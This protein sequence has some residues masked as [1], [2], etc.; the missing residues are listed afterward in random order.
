MSLRERS[1]SLLLV[2]SAKHANASLTEI[3]LECPCEKPV[4]VSSVSAAEQALADRSFDLMI[5]N[6][7]LPDDP[8]IRLAIDAC[9]LPG[10]AVL[11][12]VSSDTHD[13]VYDRVAEH[14]VFTLPKPVSRP[15]LLR[16]VSWMISARERLRKLEQRTQPVEEKMEE[17]R[18]V[19]RAKWLLI[20]ERGMTEPEAHHYIERQ[21]MDRCLSKRAVAEEIIQL[22]SENPMDRKVRLD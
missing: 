11:L 8:G 19:N 4:I 15:M 20:R 6:A 3:L 10:T 9:R 2:S 16:A 18:L 7:P 21:A 17:I 22:D 14:G 1:Y 13:Q 12:L 5:L